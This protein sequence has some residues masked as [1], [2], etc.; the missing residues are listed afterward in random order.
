LIVYTPAGDDF[1]CVEPVSHMTD[2]INRMGS[3]AEHG[4]RI[5]MPG[6]ELRGDVT[7]RIATA[8]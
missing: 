7:F 2:A 1:F 4:L 5:L 3:V 6:E 8:S